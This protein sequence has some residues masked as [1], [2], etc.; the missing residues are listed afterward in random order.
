M[1]FNA[2][3]RI[4]ICWSVNKPETLEQELHAYYMRT[5]QRVEVLEFRDKILPELM[6]AV[7]TA[8]YDDEVL[9]VFSLIKQA[10]VQTKKRMSASPNAGGRP[11]SSPHTSPAGRTRG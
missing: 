1:D 3:K 11:K 4:W 10:E 2:I 5:G 9:R 8:N 6:K 7:K